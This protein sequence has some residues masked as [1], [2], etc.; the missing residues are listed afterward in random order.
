MA[1]KNNDFEGDAFGFNT[2]S[3]DNLATEIRYDVLLLRQIWI[4]LMAINENNIEL[5]DKSLR[6]LE[7]LIMPF[8]NEEYKK[9]IESVRIKYISQY[10]NMRP[11]KAYFNQPVLINKLLDERADLLLKHAKKMG[12]LPKKILWD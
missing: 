5:Y 11:D 6:G 2:G 9:E 4:L 1:K 3:Y 8:L 7:R 12:I 10:K